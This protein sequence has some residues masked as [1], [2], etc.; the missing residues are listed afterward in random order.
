MPFCHARGDSVS[1]CGDKQCHKSCAPP[2]SR[3]QHAAPCHVRHE[4]GPT[5]RRMQWLLNKEGHR[6]SFHPAL[7]WLRVPRVTHESKF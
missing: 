7:T 6:T 3:V 1:L 4:G 2:G 5:D